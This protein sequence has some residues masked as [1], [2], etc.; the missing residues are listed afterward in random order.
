MS[1][2]GEVI[3]ACFDVTCDE[4][5]KH[6]V[7]FEQIENPNTTLAL[8]KGRPLIDAPASWVRN[9]RDPLQ[10]KNELTHL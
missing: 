6:H 7:D 1:E 4:L 8:I 3:F 5:R 10:P 2:V 9:T